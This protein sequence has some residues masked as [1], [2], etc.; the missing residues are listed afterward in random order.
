MSTKVNITDAD[1]N[2]A[3]IT[4]ISELRA[5]FTRVNQRR[6]AAGRDQR[7]C[8]LHLRQRYS[9]G[10]VAFAVSDGVPGRSGAQD[11]RLAVDGT[12]SRS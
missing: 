4:A 10:T 2:H 6:R 1:L 12:H 11:Y 3:Q 8:S 7:R 9:D 5:M